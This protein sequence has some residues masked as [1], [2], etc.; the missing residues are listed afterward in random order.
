MTSTS[1]RIGAAN[2]MI[3]HPTTE[4]I[5]AIFRGGWDFQGNWRGAV[6]APRCVFKNVEN[7]VV[8]GNYMTSLFPVDLATF[9]CGGRLRPFMYCMLASLL[10]YLEPMIDKYTISHGIIQIMCERGKI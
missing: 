4:L 5:H 3:S 1:L 7:S 9:Q 6:F 8:I 2:A 10:M